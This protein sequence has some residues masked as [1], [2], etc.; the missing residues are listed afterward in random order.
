[1]KPAHKGS[2]IFRTACALCVAA[3]T[4]VAGCSQEAVNLQSPEDELDL[5]D[6]N[7]ELVGDYAVPVGIS[8]VKLTG[9]ALVTQLDGTGGDPPQSDIRNLLIAEMQTRGV[10]QPNQILASPTT[11]MVMVS[12]YLRPGICKGDHFDV[13]VE[14]EPGDGTTSVRG[15]WLMETRLQQMIVTQDDALSKRYRSGDALALSQGWI[16]VDPSGDPAKDKDALRHGRVLGGGIAMQSRDLGLMLREQHKSVRK[17][18]TIGKV[19]NNRFTIYKQGVQE[20]VATPQT[21]GYVKLLVH[22]RYKDNI[23]RYIAVVRSIAVRET[24]IERTARMRN[25]ERQL[26]DPITSAKAALQLEAIGKDGIDVLR[27][28]LASKNQEVRF[29]SA[30]ALAYLDEPDA[31]PV[32]AQIAHEESAFRAYALCALSA[33]KDVT[34]YDQLRKLLDVS[35]AETRYGAFRALWTMEPDDPLVRGEGLGGRFSYH[36]LDVAGPPMIHVTGS[37]RPEVVLFGRRHPLVTPVK[38]QAGASIDIHAHDDEHVSVSKFAPGKSVERRTVKNDLD[39][40]IRAVAEL[41]GDY[42]NVVQ[43]LQ[44]ARAKH[45]LVSRFE[46]DALPRVDRSYLR[47]AGGDDSADG[48]PGKAADDKAGAEKAG[49][50]KESAAP[51]KAVSSPVPELFETNVD[52]RKPKKPKTKDDSIDHSAPEDTSP[53]T[54]AL[55]EIKK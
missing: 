28:G 13:A 18:D 27:K 21:D 5:L 1:M 12:A 52:E 16:L 40:I 45:A 19:I 4:I 41:G 34:A 15:G 47:E 29:Y 31:A 51:H 25:L 26:L 43:M 54:E 6:S 10:A 33:M 2:S 39:Q 23:A 9:I 22:P 3:V 49:A 50:E 30:E 24:P 35:S 37:F 46:V 32:L 8:P 55:N 44:E 42:G 36:V 7:V 53:A 14:C 11:A 17:S 38:L 20:G 48:A